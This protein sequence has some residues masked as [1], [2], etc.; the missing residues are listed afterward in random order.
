MCKQTREGEIQSMI[1]DNVNI[2]HGN[3]VT[4]FAFGLN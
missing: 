2:L 1:D 4:V 3:A